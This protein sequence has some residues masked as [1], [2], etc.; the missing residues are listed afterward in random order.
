MRSLLELQ[1]RFGAALLGREPAGSMPRGMRVYIGNVFGNWTRALTAAYPIVQKIV[2]EPF[3]EG[4]ARAY[5]RAHTSACGDLNELGARFPAFL[6]QDP[7]TQDL[8]Y[9]PDVARMEWLAHRAYYAADSAPFDLDSLR[10]TP[11]ERHSALRLSRAPGSALFS[12]D[13]PLARLWAIHQEGHQGDLTVDFHGALERILVY[14]RRWRVEV[15]S[16][17]PGEYRFLAG[18]RRGETLGDALGAALDA[19][20]EF[21]PAIALARW[22]EAGV[23]SL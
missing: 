5:G 6:A 15:K 22:V 12:S 20:R 23:I 11:P 7:D 19:D 4:L 9:L 10:A 1:E 3:F 2:G 14:R 16:V 21:D 18:A 8:P 17:A 13:W